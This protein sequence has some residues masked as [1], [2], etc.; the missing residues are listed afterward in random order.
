MRKQSEQM[1][2]ASD[3]LLAC[4]FCGYPADDYSTSVHERVTCSNVRCPIRR[5]RCRHMSR[6]QWNTRHANK[7]VA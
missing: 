4:P 7:E 2:V 3:T 6:K 1:K 5:G